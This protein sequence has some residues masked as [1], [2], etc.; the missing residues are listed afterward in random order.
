[1]HVLQ[2]AAAAL[3][4]QKPLVHGDDLVSLKTHLVQRIADRTVADLIGI[5]RRRPPAEHRRVAQRRPPHRT[6]GIRPV[7][8]VP[9]VVIARFRF[10]APVPRLGGRDLQGRRGE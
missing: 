8:C 4:A 2:S 6:G 5:I 3:Q 1:M 10:R 7:V 9:I